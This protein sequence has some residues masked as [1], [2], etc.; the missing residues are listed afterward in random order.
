MVAI[1]EIIQENQYGDIHHK[2]LGGAWLNMSIS[3]M[4]LYQDD[5]YQRVLSSTSDTSEWLVWF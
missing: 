5:G 1:L 2:N 4:S 3:T